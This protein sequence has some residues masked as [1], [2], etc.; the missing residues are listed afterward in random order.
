MRIY[1]EGGTPVPT[2][3]E[4]IAD[5]MQAAV[6]LDPVITRGFAE[7]FGCLTT[8]EEVLAR[9][10]FLQRVIACADQVSTAPP[11]GP[12]RAE[13]LELVS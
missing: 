1:R 9:P 7:I 8:G 10:G 2:D 13:L 6:L 3:A 5:V 4:K 12:D 11:S